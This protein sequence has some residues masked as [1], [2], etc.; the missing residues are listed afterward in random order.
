MKRVELHHRIKDCKTP[1][2]LRHILSVYLIELKSDKNIK[3]FRDKLLNLNSLYQYKSDSFL[4]EVVENLSEDFEAEVVDGLHREPPPVPRRSKT[5]HMLKHTIGGK[6]WEDNEW[7]VDFPS[8]IKLEIPEGEVNILKQLEIL[9]IQHALRVTGWGRAETARVL[10]CAPR[11]LRNKLNELMSSGLLIQEQDQWE[12]EVVFTEEDKAQIQQIQDKAPD[13]A[14]DGADD[15]ED[16]LKRQNEGQILESPGKQPGS[17]DHVNGVVYNLYNP[18]EEQGEAPPEIVIKTKPSKTIENDRQPEVKPSKIDPIYKPKMATCH[19]T[20]LAWID[21][22]CL[23]C[24]K[25][26]K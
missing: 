19:P 26:S 6:K 21:G 5:K 25:E 22:L 20:K 7:R 2:D 17:P 15:W 14:R 10:G 13:P 4:L 24:H 9:A 11:T 8:D 23:A 1:F 16:D 12:N 3:A 18:W